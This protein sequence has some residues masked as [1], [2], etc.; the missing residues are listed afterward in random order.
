MKILTFQSDKD[1]IAAQ[2]RTAKRFRRNG[3]TVMKTKPFY[4]PK[5][6][7]AIAMSNQIYRGTFHQATGEWDHPNNILCHGSRC[8]AEVEDLAGRFCLSP[9]V[10]VIGTDL[11]P[12]EERLTKF[13]F[14]RQNDNWVG[15]F[16]IVYSNSLD[17]TNEP[18]TTIKVWLDQLSPWGCLVLCWTPWHAKVRS[19]DCFGAT[20]D[21][22]WDWVSEHGQ[23]TKVKRVLERRFLLFVVNE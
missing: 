22:L 5:E 3:K 18:D 4:D 7:E 14:R 21:E 9:Y 12:R 2:K 13:D 23:V 20:L 6:G 19:G 11:F 8:G 15:K 17:H 16:D 10:D 1:Y